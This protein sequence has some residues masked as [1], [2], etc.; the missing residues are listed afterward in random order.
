MEK[1]SKLIPE[2]RFP[3]FLN[4]GEWYPK[5]LNEILDYE[6][7]DNYIVTDTNY[8]N[9]GMPVLTANKSFVLGYTKEDFGIYNNLPAIIFDDFTVD[10][11]YVDFPFK[12][13]SSAIKILKNKG[14]DNLKFIYELIAQIKF[15]ATEHKRYYI[16]E[17]QNLSVNVPNSNEQQKIANCLTSLDELI[18]AH[19]DKLEALKNHK[20]GLLQNLFPQEGETVPKFRFP[21]FINDGD[22]EEIALGKLAENLDSKR[23]PITSNQREKGSIPYYGASGIIDYVKDYIF[24]E[25]LLCVSEDGANLIDRNYPIA[26]TIKNKTWVN[27]HAHVLRFQN[28]YTHVLVEKYIN[29]INVQ[30]F[31]TGMAQPKLNRGK[32]D[33]IP[34][35]LPRNP[36]EQQKIAECLKEVDNLIIAQTKKIEHLKNHKKG[37]MQGLFPKLKN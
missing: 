35:P 30:D 13:K 10:N 18:T 34:I 20:K 32:L 22:W 17:Y 16:S 1:T 23:I 14:D 3:E 9:E 4:D 33:I 25:I 24:N 5:E 8:Q 12:V 7:P 31:L 21:E 2:L 37:L 11:K 29:S 28:Y 36:K 15:N 26:F 27:N 19:N 6:R